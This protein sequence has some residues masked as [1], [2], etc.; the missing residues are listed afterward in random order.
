[1]D[2]ARY[3]I[4]GQSFAAS[5][6]RLQDALARVYESSERPR[7]MCVPG[8]VEM[9]VAKHAEFVIKRMPDTGR[10]HHVTCQSFEPEPD[11]SG[12]GELLGEAIVEH[13]PE[14]VEIRTAFPLARVAGRSMP[15]REAT[16]DPAAVN[17]PRKRMSLRAV[18]H[19]LYDR[20]GFNRW[21]PAMDGRRSQA[22][23]RRYLLAAAQGVTLKGGTL[24]ERLF[25]PEQFRAAEADEIGER[26]RRRLSMLLSPETDV[27]FKMAILIGQL[28]GVEATA[29]GRRLSVKHMPDAPLYIDN[30]AWARAER[31]YGPTL[32]AVDADVER[33]PR[34]VMAALIYAKREHIYQ[35]ESLSLML[36]TDQ[37]IPLEGLHELPLIEALQRQGRQFIKPL[38]YDVKSAA[39]FPNALLLDAGATP[40]ALHVVSPFMDARER[41][42]KESALRASGETAWTWMTDKGM[43]DLPPPTKGH[44][45]VHLG[46]DRP[47]S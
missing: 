27:Q 9:Y 6:P 46:T 11:T 39:G 22:V 47:A 4:K 7:C 3:F 37:W 40:V 33:K 30:K 24:E 15:C 34:V 28:S 19:F 29:Y 41:A 45:T 12:L 25:V 36:T 2:A 23:I 42:A 18:L 16:E 44:R 32:Q 43:P 1:M 13:A 31:A 14:Q 35:V 38:K 8:G 21:Y 26:R 5:D 20:A 10:R 17:A